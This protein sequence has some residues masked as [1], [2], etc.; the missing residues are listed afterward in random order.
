ME[1]E[2]ILKAKINLM[3]RRMYTALAD[4]DLP[5]DTFPITYSNISKNQQKDKELLKRFK[6]SCDLKFKEFHGGRRFF[7]FICNKENKIVMPKALQLRA[8]HWYHN[9]LCHLVE[10]HTELTIKQHFTWNIC[11]R[12]FIKCVPDVT[13]VF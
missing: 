5:V 2:A 12:M 9:V 6:S 4:E 11:A 3:N 13:H 10:T 8:V 7:K 1:K